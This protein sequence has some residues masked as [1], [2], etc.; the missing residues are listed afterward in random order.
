[1]SKIIDEHANTEIKIVPMDNLKYNIVNY[2]KNGELYIAPATPENIAK[3]KA[4]GTWY[5]GRDDK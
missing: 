5:P 2:W 4:Q 1:M 3:A